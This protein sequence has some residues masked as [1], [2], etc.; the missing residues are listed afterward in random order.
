[1]GCVRFD[2][3]HQWVTKH[4]I[5]QANIVWTDGADIKCSLRFLHKWGILRFKRNI[6]S[7]T[8]GGAKHDGVSKRNSRYK[9]I[10][11]VSMRVLVTVFSYHN[12]EI[13]VDF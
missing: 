6:V 8:N 12:R 5:P 9:K 2:H 7:P 3:A 11:F 1:M 4:D 13:A 10:R